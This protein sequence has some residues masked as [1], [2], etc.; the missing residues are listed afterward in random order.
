M[1]ESDAAAFTVGLLHDIG[2]NILSTV[3]PKIYQTLLTASGAHGARLVM[4]ERLRFEVSHAEV[5]GSLLARW[6]L[7][8]AVV[9]SVM[10]HHQSPTSATGCERLAA[11]VQ[12]GNLLALQIAAETSLGEML[13]HEQESLKLLHLAAEDLPALLEK[14]KSG[15]EGV[16]DLLSIA[17]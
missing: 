17:S 8:P 7:P 6:K 14:T 3:E 16:R 15:L 12:I 11:T 1:D 9:A 10:A 4:G 5:G 13:P 2:K